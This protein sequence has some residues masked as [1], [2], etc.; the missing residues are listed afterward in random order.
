MENTFRDIYYNV[1]EQNKT[2]NIFFMNDNEMKNYINNYNATYNKKYDFQKV[3]DEI[4]YIKQYSGKL[5]KEEYTREGETEYLND[6]CNVNNKYDSEKKENTFRLLSFNIHSFIKSCSNFVRTQFNLFELTTNKNIDTR[7]TNDIINLC[8]NVKPDIICFQEYSPIFIGYDSLNIM[9]FPKYYRNNIDNNMTNVVYK[10]I[11]NNIH[12]EVL[13]N[14]RYFIG[15]LL[16]TKFNMIDKYDL[17]IN[18]GKSSKESRPI[19]GSKI[20]INNIELLIFNIHPVAEYRDFKEYESI[21]FR[22][23]KT[24]VDMI[25]IKYPPEKYNIL[26]CGDFNNHHD[27]IKK[28]MREKLFVTVHDFYEKNNNVYT[29]YHGT[30]LDFIFVSSHFLYDFSIVNH[31]VLEV[32]YSDHYPVMFDFRINNKQYE[33]SQLTSVTRYLYSFNSIL[34]YNDININNKSLFLTK[35]D[36]I[37]LLDDN[38]KEILNIDIIKNIINKRI[39]T[40]PKGT[41]IVH[42]TD[43]ILPSNQSSNYGFFELDDHELNKEEKLEVPKSF[44]LLNLPN[45]SFMSWYGIN[46]ETNFKRLLI[47]RLTKDINLI[48]LYD[49]GDSLKERVECRL[50]S[51]LKL[52]NYY[53]K[54]FNF[55]KIYN[56]E[57]TNTAMGYDIMRIL[58]IIFNHQI[59]VNINTTDDKYNTN[60]FYG[61]LLADTIAN[62]FAF[63]KKNINHANTVSYWHDAELYEGIEIQLFAHHFCTEF[64]GVYYNNHFINSIEWKNKVQSILM[65]NNDLKQQLNITNEINLRTSF[66]PSSHQKNK[67]IKKNIKTFMIFII[68]YIKSKYYDQET[69]NNLS[70]LFRQI[71]NYSDERLKFNTPLAINILLNDFLLCLVNAKYFYCLNNL[72][73]DHANIQKT[74]Y[75]KTNIYNILNDINIEELYNNFVVYLTKLLYDIDKSSKLFNIINKKEIKS[76]ELIKIII[77]KV[78]KFICNVNKSRLSHEPINYLNIINSDIK[79]SANDLNCITNTVKNTN[80]VYPNILIPTNT[81]TIPSDSKNISYEFSYGTK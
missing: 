54:R 62:D 18:S 81:S 26:I 59:L 3:K 36:I 68:N 78:I 60:M 19:I 66:Q 14:N 33:K 61:F 5:Y 40:I 55:P 75:N 7:N 34:K 47:Y 45:E 20:Q 69:E 79:L 52:Y 31:Q 4:N 72:S 29:G 76:I 51:Y 16:M 27:Y 64:E 74:D 9:N 65:K 28:F 80:R 57:Y 53:H 63:F 22:Q 50:D 6:F 2:N 48:N 10:D 15:N 58:W 24:F 8:K 12:S 44:T 77:K 39:V 43:F 67:I 49:C 32:N 21:N 13:P 25:S 70:I 41:Y 73:C 1:G 46:T 37:K 30:Y 35:E 23:I 56:E 71:F 38:M 17:T 42:G 11:E